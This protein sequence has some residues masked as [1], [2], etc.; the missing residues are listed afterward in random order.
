MAD[1][2]SKINFNTEKIL[3]YLLMSGGL[4]AAS[5]IVPKLPAELLKVYIKNRKFQK[6]QFNRDIKRL[7]GNGEVRISEKG[8]EITKQG[9]TRMLRYQLDDIEL[10]KPERWDKK[11]RLVIFDIPDYDKKKSNY[12]RYKLRDLGFLQYQKSIFIFPYPCRDEIEYIKE[13]CEMSS[14]VKFIVAE[15]IDDE[16]YFRR[17]FGLIK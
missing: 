6:F 12:L 5:I 17:K 8:I 16:K 11:W 3:Y 9:K 13:I 7:Q 4:I 10:K 14:Y 1:K 2:Y 15:K